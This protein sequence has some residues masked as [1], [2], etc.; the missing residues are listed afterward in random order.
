MCFGASAFGQDVRYYDVEVVIFESLSP[1]ERSS[2]QWPHESGVSTPESFVELG[3]PYPGK[4]P[5]KFNPANTFAPFKKQ[6]YRLKNE[7]KLLKKSKKFRVLTHMGWR[8]PGMPADQALA[9]HVKRLIP[10]LPRSDERLGRTATPPVNERPFLEAGED[11][12]RRPPSNYLLNGFIQLSLSR[13]L[14]IKADLAYSE[15]IPQSMWSPLMEPESVEQLV[16]DRPLVYHLL[17]TRRM[18]SGELHYIDHP[19]LG[20]LVMVTPVTDVKTP[21]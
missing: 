3:L 20:L 2:E 13:Y 9:V 16:E 21:G 7:V 6:Q 10:P 1:A 14:H 4:L 12:V 11:E 5:T 15:E 17:Q 8:Q 18:R 19:V